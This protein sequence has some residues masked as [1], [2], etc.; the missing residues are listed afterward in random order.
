MEKITILWADDEIELLK[1]HI[2]FLEEKGYEVV[3]T[4]SGNE[5]IEL[6]KRQTF[7][8][9]FLDENMPGLSGI[10]TLIQ[11]KNLSPA[12][13]VVMITK[14]EEESIMN[15]AIGSNIADYLIKP[16]NPNQILLCIKKIL[17]QKRLVSEKTTSTYQQEFRNIW[18][19]LMDKLDH[20]QWTDV[21][22]KIAQWDLRLEKS[23]DQGMNEVLKSQLTEANSLFSKYIE[24]N[25]IPWLNG[26]AKDKPIFSHTLLRE[27]LFP[28]LTGSTPVFLIVIDNLRYDQWKVL[29]PIFENYFRVV[30]DELYFSILPTATHYS[31]NALFAGLLPTEIEKIYPTLW[32]NEEDEGTKNQHEEELFAMLL[33]RFGK[34]IKFSYSKVLNLSFGK[35]LVETLPN[36]MSNK[37]NVIVYNFV[38]MLSHARTEMEVIQELANDEA[39]Y[40]SLTLS[41]FE[42]SPLLD[43]IK[44][45]A[46]KKAHLMI[47]TDHGSIRVQNP[48]K[49]VGDKNT[50]TNLRYK[51]GKSLQYE[52]KDVFEIKNPQDAFLP[53]VNVSTS[54]VFAKE[55]KFFAYPNNYN[56]Y[57][58]YY[59]NTFQHGGISMEEMMIPYVVLSPK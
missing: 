15:D 56:Y 50:N 49:V 51:L 5:A 16:V 39:A 10:E 45:V 4:N 2:I 30:E 3:T 21:Y 38:D 48:T 57:V 9:I 1:P 32:L 26:V 52:K 42:H 12:T 8:I 14:S 59:R 55:N 20:H 34:D 27:K 35:K 31:R 33:K 24:S 40:R 36:M 13:P 46:E 43:I 28:I 11:L 54:Y 58:S 53:R 44:F 18:A 47:T 6:A 19:T 17:D 7:E 22:K 29:Q 25:Y 23:D 41:W 37:L